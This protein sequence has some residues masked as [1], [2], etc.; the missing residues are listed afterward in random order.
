M[1]S[2]AQEA[3]RLH[4]RLLKCT[5]EVEHS[6]SYWAHTDGT[7]HTDARKAHDEYWFGARSLGRVEVLLTNL[8]ARFDAFAP[9]LEVLHRWPDMSPETRRAICH[10]HLML[11]DPLYRGFAGGYLTSRRSGARPTVTRSLVV[12]W[13]SE[14]GKGRWSMSTRIQF[15]TQLLSSAHAAGLLTTIRDPR[16]LALPRVP[17]EALEYLL[18]LLREIEFDGTLLENPYVASVGLEGPVLEDRLRGLAGLAFRRQG[19]LVDF[20]WRHGDL[21]AWAEANFGEPRRH[22]AGGLA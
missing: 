21:R 1:T 18:H 6:R 2:R 13:V 19:A 11:S 9:A 3:R 5:L 17:D 22:A 7:P 10:F 4:T 8:R 16:P 12:A 20:G 15:A 14:Q